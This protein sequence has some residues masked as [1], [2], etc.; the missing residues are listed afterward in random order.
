MRQLEVNDLIHGAKGTSAD[1]TLNRVSISCRASDE[2]GSGIGS[3]QAI[4]RG[5]QGHRNPSVL[6]LRSAWGSFQNIA[7]RG[8]EGL[9]GYATFPSNYV[10]NPED[11]RV[12]ILCSSLSGGSM[13]NLNMEPL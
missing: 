9:L 6:P 4:R 2:G 12:V 10:T 11:D 8:G 3:G 7:Q 13:T 5:G 1:A